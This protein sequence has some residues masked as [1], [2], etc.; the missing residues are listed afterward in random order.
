[1]AIAP[2]A[3]CEA[4]GEPGRVERFLQLTDVVVDRCGRCG[5]V[6]LGGE[7]SVESESDLYQCDHFEGGWAE[8]FDGKAV[9]EEQVESASTMLKLG[10]AELRDYP[11][12]SA[13][14]D[15]GCARGHLLRALGSA[16]GWQELAGIDVSPQMIEVG[17]REFGLDLRC[18]AVEEA[19]LPRDHYQLITMFDVLEHLASPR[20][21]LVKL[22][23]V[24]RPGGWL[25]IEVPS[26]TTAFRVLTRWAFHV[27]GGRIRGPLQQLYHRNHLSYFTKASLKTLLGSVGAERVVV[28]TKEAHIT[29]FGAHNYS[30]GKRA[31][32]RAVC[33]L[34]RVLGTQAKLLVAC[35]RPAGT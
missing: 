26:E 22:M 15:I 9:V 4:C 25:I 12:E 8:A 23:S 30:P 2:G 6:F 33:L 29:R 34:D 28:T 10:G 27:S 11:P 18:G 14:L 7:R 19:E 13:A 32:I 35:R 20:A 5:F 24:L 31:V 1:M 3:K 16:T 21:A 17:R